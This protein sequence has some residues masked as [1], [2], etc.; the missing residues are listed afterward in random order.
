MYDQDLVVCCAVVLEWY[1][2]GYR[3]WIGTV[4]GEVSQGGTSGSL[5]LDVAAFEEEENG[6]ESV[7]VNR[8]H[9]C[10]RACQYEW[11]YQVGRV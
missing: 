1:L 9:I 2:V 8:A 7:L 3:S 4:Y 10:D 6:L 11:T 5:D